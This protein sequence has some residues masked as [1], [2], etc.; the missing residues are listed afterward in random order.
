MGLE[1]AIN[2]LPETIDH[3]NNKISVTEDKIKGI[4]S[5]QT[6]RITVEVA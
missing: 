3:I 4:Q 2:K 1:E 5:D 6:E